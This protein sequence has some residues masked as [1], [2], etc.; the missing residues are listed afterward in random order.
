MTTV[1]IFVRS[2]GQKNVKGP[3]ASCKKSNFE[4]IR[5]C[6]EEGGVSGYT[7]HDAAAF[8]GDVDLCGTAGQALDAMLVISYS[9]NSFEWL[10]SYAQ[11]A[12]DCC[13]PGKRQEVA[14]LTGRGSLMPG[15]QFND[16]FRV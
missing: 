12:G 8:C 15:M 10:E 2:P 16:S 4:S 9:S 1:S 11:P 3:K 7:S 14:V 6:Q 13:R 5:V